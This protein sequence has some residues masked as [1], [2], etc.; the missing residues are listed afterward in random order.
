V[1][2]RLKLSPNLESLPERLQL[3]CQQKLPYQDFLEMVLGDE[4]ARRDCIGADLRA[5]PTHRPHHA[6]RALGR[7]SAVTFKHQLWNELRSLDI[8]RPGAYL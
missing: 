8:R 1:L 4:A 5:V 3:D 2:R 7:Q 6:L